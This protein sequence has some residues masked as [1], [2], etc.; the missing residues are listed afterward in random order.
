M[1]MTHPNRHRHLPVLALL[2]AIAHIAIVVLALIG[3]TAPYVTGGQQH[4]DGAL[5]VL[6]ASAMWIPLHTLAA[7]GL[8]L[9]AFDWYPRHMPDLACHVSSGVLLAWGA[10]TFVWSITR[11]PPV[12]LLGPSLTLLLGF[13]AMWCGAVWDDDPEGD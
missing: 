5:A 2:L 7:V 1:P 13:V 12:S 4:L 9:A 11:H 3:R 6:D 8:F 10:I